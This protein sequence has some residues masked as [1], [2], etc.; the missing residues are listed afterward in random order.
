MWAKI[1]GQLT[2]G[3]TKKKPIEGTIVILMR[4]PAIQEHF[5]ESAILSREGKIV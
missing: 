3:T 4:A 1:S 2:R 5:Y